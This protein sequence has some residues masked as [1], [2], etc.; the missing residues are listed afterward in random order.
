MSDAASD[1]SSAFVTAAEDVLS[2]YDQ[3]LVL[4][5]F[6]LDR[7]AGGPWGM[8]QPTELTA[9]LKAAGFADVQVSARRLPVSFPGGSAQLIRTIALTP[10]AAEV[11]ALSPERRAALISAAQQRLAPMVTNGVLSFDTVSNIGLATR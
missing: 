7:Y 2:I 4:S 11:A 9:L 3:A 5:L 8:P 10:A 1:W 6:E